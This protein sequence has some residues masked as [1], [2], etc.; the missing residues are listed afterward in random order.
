LKGNLIIVNKTE[1]P[2]IYSN[3]K[4][5]LGQENKWARPYVI[6]QGTFL[7]DNAGQNIAPRDSLELNVY[8]KFN[9][10]H[11]FKSDKFIIQDSTK[12]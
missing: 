2:I 3:S 1:K 4:I 6:G 5:L 7:V 11:E 10:N 8:W 9:E 12:E